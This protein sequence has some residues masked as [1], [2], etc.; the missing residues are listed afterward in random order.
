MVGQVTAG[1]DQ[2]GAGAHG[3]VADDQV[4]ESFGA[5]AIA[6]GAEERCERPVHDGLA[7]AARSVVTAG[8]ATL[9]AR[10]DHESPEFGALWTLAAERCERLERRV[11]RLRVLHSGSDF[12]GDLL[13]E[14]EL[15][16]QPRGAPRHWHR[17]QP[18]RLDPHP[19]GAGF[20]YAFTQRG[21]RRTFNDLCRAARV[22]DIVTRSIS[23]HAHRAYATPLLDSPR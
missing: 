8:A 13:V 12:L 4:Q 2:E 19:R 3:G 17:E 7:Q 14:G 21:M 15:F 9:G 11:R 10:L 5:A 1:R 20:A 16:R 22:E 6:H 23:G 18:A